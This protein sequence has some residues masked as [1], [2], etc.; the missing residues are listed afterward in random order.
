LVKEDL[1]LQSKPREARKFHENFQS[2][3]FELS[4][5]ELRKFLELWVSSK[6]IIH[7]FYLLN[8]MRH[9]RSAHP[10]EKIVL[11][12]KRTR[13]QSASG[14][15]RAVSAKQRLPEGMTNQ[16]IRDSIENDTSDYKIDTGNNFYSGAKGDKYVTYKN[17]V[18]DHYHKDQDEKQRSPAREEP[19]RKESPNQ[20]EALRRSKYQR[21]LKG[22]D[23]TYLLNILE[24][25]V[26]K[27][28]RL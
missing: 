24:E 25:I 28:E 27:E 5:H 17:E 2:K 22:I 26:I 21:D 13:A 4:F 8:I 9:I 3:N 1:V 6:E 10:F 15:K 7:E 11:K 18:F 16:K 23:G 12:G 19:Q 14:Q 20:S